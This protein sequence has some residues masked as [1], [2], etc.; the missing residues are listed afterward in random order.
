MKII[1]C[2]DEK[3][4]LLK[5]KALLE[6]IAQSNNY[7]IETECCL[8]PQECVDCLKKGRAD[9]IIVDMYLKD[10]LGIDLARTLRGLQSDFKLIFI[11]EKNSYAEET[12]E[13]NADGYLLKPFDENLF[14]RTVVKSLSFNRKIS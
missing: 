5:I 7:H 3:E 12:Y 10:C 14:G 4:Y 2:D 8:S 11:S 1:I 13:V 6:K 9:L